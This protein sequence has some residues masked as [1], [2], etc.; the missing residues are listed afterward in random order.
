MGRGPRRADVVQAPDQHS[1]TAG[2]RLVQFIG[3]APAAAIE[4]RVVNA[5]DRVQSAAVGEGARRANRNL[6][7]L[8]I[9]EEGVLLEDLLRAPASG[10]VE[11]RHYPRAI[12]ELHFVDPVLEGVQ[13]VAER[14]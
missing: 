5:L 1:E 11:L 2:E 3:G 14:A 12:G 10:P 7:R 9:G 6:R 13:G 4:D 8:T